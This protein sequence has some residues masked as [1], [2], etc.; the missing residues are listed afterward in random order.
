[1]QPRNRLNGVKDLLQFRFFEINPVRIG[2]SGFGQRIE[3]RGQGLRLTGYDYSPS[4]EALFLHRPRQLDYS[5]PGLTLKSLKAIDNQ[6]AAVNTRI[7]DQFRDAMTEIE[8]MSKF[9]FTCQPSSVILSGEL[10]TA[11]QDTTDTACIFRTGCFE[12]FPIGP[13]I[14]VVYEIKTRA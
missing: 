12:P 7:L 14:G 11:T 9:G 13:E 1:M 6:R 3:G 8:R 4:N 10:D 5:F 2:N